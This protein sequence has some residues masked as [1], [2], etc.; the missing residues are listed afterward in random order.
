MLQTKTKPVKVV[1]HGLPACDSAPQWPKKKANKKA[2]DIEI[3]CICQP[4][5]LHYLSKL[6]MEHLLPTVMLSC[7]LNS[8]LYTPDCSFQPL[9]GN[10]LRITFLIPNYAPRGPLLRPNSGSPLAEASRGTL[11]LHLAPRLCS[12]F[13]FISK[14]QTKTLVSIHIHELP[15]LALSPHIHTHTLKWV[16]GGVL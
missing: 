2:V 10:V 12:T 6:H 8:T 11:W 15:A 5:A 9:C 13:S 7:S 4:A 3:V 14:G 1:L 16:G